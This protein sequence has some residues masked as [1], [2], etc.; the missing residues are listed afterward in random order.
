MM[1]R[2]LA[3]RLCLLLA[4]AAVSRQGF[5]IPAQ[6]GYNEPGE[7]KGQLRSRWA[8]PYVRESTEKVG[9]RS[10]TTF[11]WFNET[12]E[13]LRE[14][15]GGILQPGFLMVN[16]DEQTIV[17]GLGGDW[18]LTL[19]KTPDGMESYVTGTPDGRFF[20]HQQFGGGESAIDSYRDG[21]LVAQIGPYPDRDSFVHP[22]DDG[23]LSLL[24]WDSPAKAT[25]QVMVVGPDG[26]ERFR[27]QCEPK[28]RRQVAGPDGMGA[29]LTIYGEHGGGGGE[30]GEYFAWYTAE[31]LQHSLDV[32]PNAIF[33]GWAPGSHKALIWTSTEESFYSLVDWDTGKLLWMV[34]CPG[35]GQALSIELTPDF[36]L[37]VVA[38]LYKPGP[39][40][41][42]SWPLEGENSPWIRTFYA[43]SYQ[44]GRPIAYW[45]A[46]YPQRLNERNAGSFMR[47]GEKLYFVTNEEFTEISLEDITAKRNGWSELPGE[48]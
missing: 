19:P 27:V 15:T 36:A 45:R 40:G 17:Y 38:E 30:D 22:D 26:K 48:R 6:P 28:A 37:F 41:G 29:L 39:W 31:G 10:V 9:E 5:T 21:K 42:E 32:G 18:Q 24:V 16:E 8:A 2:T 1:I 4:V 14:V 11:T 25:P 7:R 43:L 44:D 34:P 23:S 35:G 33:R 13:V 12:G 3:V 20:I 46:K 47:R